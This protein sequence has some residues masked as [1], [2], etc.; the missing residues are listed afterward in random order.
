MPSFGYIGSPMYVLKK[1]INYIHVH[2]NYTTKRD[3]QYNPSWQNTN[4]P[5]DMSDKIAIGQTETYQQSGSNIY[6]NFVY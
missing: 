4:G 2:V 6:P 5:T 3:L 1:N